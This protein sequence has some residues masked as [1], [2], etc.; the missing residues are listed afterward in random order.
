MLSSTLSQCKLHGLLTLLLLASVSDQPFHPVSCL[1]SPSSSVSILSS[2]NCPSTDRCPHCAE[3]GVNAGTS[4]PSRSLRK[5]ITHLRHLLDFWINILLT[6]L[7]W[8]PGILHAWYVPLLF[9]VSS[10]LVP[11]PPTLGGSS[12]EAKVPCRRPPCYPNG[13]KAMDS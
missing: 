10:V 12:L 4:R 11:T 6:I 13:R 7:G 5:T 9:L 8:I 1:L 2:L 3:R